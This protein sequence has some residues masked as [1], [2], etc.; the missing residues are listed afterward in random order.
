MFA[1][2]PAA[3]PAKDASLLPGNWLGSECAGCGHAVTQAESKKMATLE[4]QLQELVDKYSKEAPPLQ[5][6]AQTTS[7]TL[8][9]LQADEAFIDKH[10]CQHVLADLAWEQFGSH[11]ASKQRVAD[12]RRLLERRCEFHKAAYPGL[13]GAH[14]WTLEALGDCLRSAGRAAAAAAAE[15]QDAQAQDAPGQAKKKRGTWQAVAQKD[16]EAARGYYTDAL[17]ILR[18]MF[19]NE[20][21]Y[22]TEVE[23][24]LAAS[25]PASQA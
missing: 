5:T 16:A 21:E 3:G 1:K 24:K 25:P 17:R 6:A 9:Q 14:A 12:Q 8:K 18:L 15:Q 4:K 23:K 2:T 22:V 19:G 11:Y 20:H 10:F 7:F 13:S